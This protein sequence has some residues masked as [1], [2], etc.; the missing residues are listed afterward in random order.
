MCD[1]NKFWRSDK[2]KAFWW[3]EN[4]KKSCA[5]KM[6][7]S[8]R[9]SVKKLWSVSL[10]VPVAVLCLLGPSAVSEFFDGPLVQVS[11]KKIWARYVCHLLVGWVSAKRSLI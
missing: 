7:W 11:R 6:S 3:S 2:V 9:L 10:S 4:V 8:G 5:L 1:V